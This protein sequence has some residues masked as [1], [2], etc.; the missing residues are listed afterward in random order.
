MKLTN[1]I[2]KALNNPR[3]AMNYFL[4]MKISNIL[5]DKQF[6][7][8]KYRMAYGKKLNLD[9]PQNYNE[10]LQW[11]KLYN[12]NPEY[13]NLVDKYEVKKYIEKNIGKEYVIPTLGIYKKFEDI[14]FDELP[15]KFVIKCTHDSGG[16]VVC[17][18]KEKLDIKL[19]QKI[20]NKSLK[21]N[22][23][24]KGREW[25]Y[26]N[27]KP[28]I[29]IEKLMEI[30]NI[31]KNDSTVA[32]KEYIDAETLQ[33]EQGLLDYKFM[34]FNGEVKLMF[35]DIGVIG[36][37]IGHAK[38][39]YRNVY[40]EK[41]ELLPV[42]ETRSN[43]PTKINKPKNFSKMVEI[44]QNLSKGIPHV[45]V[46]LYNIDGKIY[47]GELTFF[48]GSGLSNYFIPEEW[49]EKLGNYINLNKKL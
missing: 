17:K 40:D 23:Y 49:N 18:D 44:A 1:K 28:R 4:N 3:D 42:L 30:G 34:C 6:L 31:E 29:I 46:D 10:K 7:K 9:N 24:L 35:L 36:K 37:G 25:P 39:Y 27:V 15:N 41:F 45:R 13:T 43:Y 48:H 20:I 19:A 38:E 22:Y 33:K 8:L 11:L 26:K 5:P 2:K 16:L 14:N 47:F 21:N 12:R 32:N